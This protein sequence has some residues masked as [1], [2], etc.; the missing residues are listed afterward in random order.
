ME[1]FNINHTLFTLWGYNVCLLELVGVVLGVCSVWLATQG[2]AVNFLVGIVGMSFLTVFF[3]QKGLYSSSILQII[4]ICFCAFGYYNW[5]KPK[6][7]EQTTQRTKK[8]TV[9]TKRQR[10]LIVATILIIVAIWGSIMVFTKSGFLETLFPET[11]NPKGLG[12]LDAYILIVVMFGMYLRTQKKYENW[13][14]FLSSDT[15][16]I[17]LYALTGAYFVVLMCSIYWLLDIKAIIS[18]RKEMKSY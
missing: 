2:K 14:L 15:M 16:G 13:F 8:I 1:I 6:K 9:L 5:T 11:Y 3:Y 18:W 10:I 4:S 17:I 12:Y 7:D